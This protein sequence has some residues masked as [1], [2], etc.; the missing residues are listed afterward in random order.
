ML[1][2]GRLG[3]ARRAGCVDEHELVVE[4]DRVLDGSVDGAAFGP[5]Q[6]D[7]KVAAAEADHQA[8]VVGGG[9]GDE[10]RVLGA[11]VAQGVR[12]FREGWKQGNKVK[13]TK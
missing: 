13:K 2:D 8:V 3:H 4:A 12:N 6:L 10:T 5:A 1:D 9:A 7:G 11:A